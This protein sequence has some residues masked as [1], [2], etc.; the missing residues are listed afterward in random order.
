MDDRVDFDAGFLA[1][2][3]SIDVKKLVWAYKKSREIMR[4]MSV[5]RGE[6]QPWHPP[7]PSSSAAVCTKVDAPLPDD[8]K[9]IAYTAED[10]AVIEQYIREKVETTWHSL[11]TCKMGPRERMAAVDENLNVHGVEGLKI[12]DLSIAPGNVG[13]NLYNTAMVV[14]EKA[15]DIFIRELGLA[16]A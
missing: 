13:A 1:D 14:G 16:S 4:R 5:Y 15:A 10:D 9:D 8:V 12:A 7:F 6:H 3:N 11:G 2:P